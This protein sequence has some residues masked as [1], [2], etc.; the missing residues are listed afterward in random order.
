VGVEFRLYVAAQ[1]LVIGVIL[2]QDD[3][4]KEFVITY[5]SQ[6]LLDTESRYTYIEKLCLSLYYSCTKCRH[7][8]LSDSCTVVCQYDIVKYMLHTRF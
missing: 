6:R 5:L 8:L 1:E 3:K 4:G 2:T 7:Y